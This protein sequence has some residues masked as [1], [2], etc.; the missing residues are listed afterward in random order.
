[1][2]AEEL[3]RQARSSRCWGQAASRSWPIRRSLLP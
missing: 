2:I 1:M 3:L